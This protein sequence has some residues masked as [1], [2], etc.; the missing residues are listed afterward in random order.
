LGVVATVDLSQVGN[1]TT[2]A[3][4]AEQSE[5][6]YQVFAP[7]ARLAQA[8]IGTMAGFDWAYWI[9]AYPN[10]NNNPQL[11]LGF[12]TPNLYV[13]QEDTT[14]GD[15]SNWVT[16]GTISFN[17]FRVATVP[18][19]TWSLTPPRTI[20]FANKSLINTS[21][22]PTWSWDFGD[23]ATDNTNNP[24]PQHVYPRA[25]TFIAT[26]TTTDPTGTKQFTGVIVIGFQA[27]M[28]IQDLGIGGVINGQPAHRYTILDASIGAVAW[29]WD[30]GDG[31]PIYSQQ[32][33]PNPYR[34][35]AGQQYTI[36]LTV[37]DGNGN[38][39]STS[40]VINA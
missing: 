20:L 15:G 5:V 16:L 8:G 38:T 26:L 14:L 24:S 23:G 2:T 27:A 21:F 31:T 12:T 13:G 37:M 22:P 39:A 1:T 9:S 17:L 7:F 19:F 40:Q 10:F 4:I 33:P 28:T 25:G 6:C 11:G 18:L 35:I 34:Y 36:T 3:V 32:Q 29:S 30:F